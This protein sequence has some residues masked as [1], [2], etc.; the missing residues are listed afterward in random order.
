MSIKKIC[1]LILLVTPCIAL[2]KTPEPKKLVS[3]IDSVGLFKN[4]Y[5]YMT[6]SAKIDKAGVYI[7]GNIFRPVHGTFWI[8]NNKDIEVRM[9][10]QDV[11]SDDFYL[12]K[13][14]Q[15]SL[16]GSELTVYLIGVEK[17]IHGKVIK[18]NM[19]VKSTGWEQILNS[20]RSYYSAN[21][22][23]ASNTVIIKNKTGI[24]AIKT[25]QI[26]HFIITNLTK[27]TIKK[28]V[29]IVKVKKDLKSPLVF[30][31]LTKG[32][33]WAPSYRID[34][35]DPKKLFIEQ[36]AVIKNELG[37]IDATD[38]Y[39][40]SGFP[41]VQ[42]AHVESP[43]SIQT[44]WSSFFRQLGQ[45][46]SV[47][48][49]SW[50]SNVVSQQLKMSENMAASSSFNSQAE[51]GKDIHYQLLGKLTLD[52]NESLSRITA[53]A[54]TKYQRIV[55]WNIPQTRQADGKYKSVDNDKIRKGVWDTLNF[56]NPLPFPMTT[57]AVVIEANKK[58]RGQRM[59]YW[60]DQNETAS[61]AITKALSIRAKSTEQE[62]AA[63]R[64]AVTIAGN[65]YQKTKVKGLL[66]I[67]NHRSKAVTMIIHKK[68]HGEF[69][70]A[71]DNP[72]IKHLTD[73][74]WSVNRSNQLTWKLTLKPG[75]K[76]LISFHYT[77]LVK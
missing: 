56:K 74:T 59:T 28:P 27:R 1:A 35:T 77:I 8:D 2:A 70:K 4:G 9:K 7:V 24:H 19:D 55:E 41:S 34:I 57:A 43:L 54:E 58:F 10:M 42:F 62:N 23:A 22:P 37:K 75:E 39:V 20:P 36:K 50:T 76:K 16:V 73:G 11:S 18:N 63:N 12:S 47:G 40:I 33:S 25:S 53:S 67:S 6:H 38:V 60:V 48:G 46:P 31:Y 15:N 13:N 68:F 71:D 72:G 30:R 3:K 26:A 49:S 52:K 66:N 64:T 32:F 21:L 51:G 14:I 17:P 45:K 29:L 44:S 65:N 5:A 69:V 61:I